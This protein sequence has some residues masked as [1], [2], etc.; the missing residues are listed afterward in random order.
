MAAPKPTD[1]GRPRRLLLACLGGLALA[2]S[3]NLPKPPIPTKLLL[4]QGGP[5]SRL[6][7]RLPMAPTAVGLATAER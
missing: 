4:T 3:C 2:S 7:Y 6:E 5:D 1:P